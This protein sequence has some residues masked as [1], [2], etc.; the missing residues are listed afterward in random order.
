MEKTPSSSGLALIA[1]SPSFADNM[2]VE[3]RWPHMGAGAARA[4]QGGQIVG[5]SGDPSR[6]NF[7]YCV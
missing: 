5:S 6:R 3:R 7:M 1:A 4:A 2:P